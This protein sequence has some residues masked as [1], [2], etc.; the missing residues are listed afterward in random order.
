MEYRKEKIR[1]DYHAFVV[2]NSNIN[3]CRLKNITQESKRNKICV[4]GDVLNDESERKL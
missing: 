3:D 4:P 2:I 1:K